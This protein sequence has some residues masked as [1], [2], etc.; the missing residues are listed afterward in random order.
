VLWCCR[1]CWVRCCWQHWVLLSRQR[2]LQHQS[3]PG[4]CH[5][6]PPGAVQRPR[7]FRQA[8]PTSRAR[9]EVAA[10]G[11]RPRAVLQQAASAGQHACRDPAAVAVP[12]SRRCRCWGGGKGILLLLAVQVLG[13][14]VPRGWKQPLLLPAAA[15]AAAAAAQ[16]VYW[17]WLGTLRMLRR[18]AA[19][20]AHL[21]VLGLGCELVRRTASSL[22]CTGSGCCGAGRG[23]GAGAVRGAGGGS[24]GS[25]SRG[26]S[27][28]GWVQAYAA[29]TSGY[30][31]GADMPNSR[32]RHIKCN[33]EGTTRRD[34]PRASL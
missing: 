2:G 28:E 24:R 18:G 20:A 25:S 8:A 26:S 5:T 22:C 14:R 32:G 12:H 3:P 33:Q 13:H 27:S 15:A 30:E 10:A 4:C 17:L 7:H 9:W 19:G 31:K 29:T 11:T 6:S 34:H 23:W 16:G 1:A 21:W